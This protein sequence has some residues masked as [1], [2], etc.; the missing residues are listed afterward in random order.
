MKSEYARTN[1]LVSFSSHLTE[2][3]P[4]IA[5]AMSFGRLFAMNV[6]LT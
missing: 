5:W 6:A 4:L 1:E 3:I 2:N